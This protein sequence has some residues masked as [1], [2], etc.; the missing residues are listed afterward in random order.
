MDEAS[1]EG[2]QPADEVQLAARMEAVGRLAGGMAHE[3]NNI[4]TAVNGYADL[5]LA[6]LRADDPARGDIL[7]IRRAGDRGAALTGQLLAL[8]GRQVMAPSEVDLDAF[9]ADLADSLREV[10]GDGVRVVLRLAAHGDTVL[11]DP[12]QLKDAILRLASRA[13]EAMPAG[14]ELTISTQAVDAPRETRSDPA[15]PPGRWLRLALA[16]TGAGMDA[17]TRAHAFEPYFTTQPRSKGAGLSLAVAWGIV[18]QSG[19]HV[20]LTSEPG[21]GT[22]FRLYLPIAEPRSSLP[23]GP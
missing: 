9:L 15:L 11:V 6:E 18:T 2:L 3:F 5:A 8:G 12:R 16:D 13:P 10:A 23:A 20:R 21:Q 4:L 17:Q 7:E 19:G 1:D 14:G 22:T